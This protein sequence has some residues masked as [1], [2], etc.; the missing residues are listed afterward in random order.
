MA[1]SR[2]GVW[3]V[4]I[5]SSSL[6]AVRL[7]RA[8]EGYEVIGFDYIEHSRML[9]MEGLTEEDRQTIIGETLHKFVGANRLRRFVSTRKPVQ[10]RAAG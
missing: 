5:G 10:S 3:A 8:E 4:D 9:T 6:K 7:A 1:A 2:R